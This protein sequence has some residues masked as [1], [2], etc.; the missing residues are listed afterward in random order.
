M[1]GYKGYVG[2]DPLGL[3]PPSLTTPVLSG[4]KANYSTIMINTIEELQNIPRLVE[5][6]DA[7]LQTANGYA[8]RGL[9]SEVQLYL[10]A[11]RMDIFMATQKYMNDRREAE[12]TSANAQA[13]LGR[14]VEFAKDFLTALITTPPVFT[15]AWQDN[16]Q[17][18]PGMGGAGRPPLVQ[19]SPDPDPAKLAPLAVQF[20]D[21][22]IK[23]LGK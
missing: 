19:A 10:D 15:P 14:R 9:T 6:I 18:Q 5:R 11:H 22:L 13:L 21:E 7:T 3:N 16:G 23:A 8:L 1:N 2:D 17:Y 4:S 12:V 20:A